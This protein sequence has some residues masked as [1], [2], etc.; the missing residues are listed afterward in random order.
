M[1]CYLMFLGVC[2]PQ[3]SMTDVLGCVPLVG[4]PE[5]LSFV[6]L[7]RLKAIG[8]M[9]SCVSVMCICVQGLWVVLRKVT[10]QSSV[11]LTPSCL[12]APLP[13]PYKSVFLRWGAGGGEQMPF[14]LQAQCHR[15]RLCERTWGDPGGYPQ[16]HLWTYSTHLYIIYLFEDGGEGSLLGTPSPGDGTIIV[17]L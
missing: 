7:D 4:G 15:R 2:D 17:S 8:I 14:L 10:P 11:W 13:Y 12:P 3:M 5:R 1:Q 16:T 6:T 9:C